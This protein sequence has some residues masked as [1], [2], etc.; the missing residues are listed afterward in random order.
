MRELL[1]AC[2]AVAAV[3][4]VMKRKEK[5]EERKAKREAEALIEQM[6]RNSR[7]GRLGTF[8]YLKDDE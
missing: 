1:L 2:I 5:R 6:R 8:S 4:G 3:I 7:A